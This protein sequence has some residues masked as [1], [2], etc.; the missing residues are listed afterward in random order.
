MIKD[1]KHLLEL[2]KRLQTLNSCGVDIS[3]TLI[4]D[5]S[6]KKIVNSICLVCDCDR[7]TVWIVDEIN[8]EL[9]SKVGKGLSTTIRLP[10]DVGIVGFVAITGRRLVIDDAYNDHRF[11]S[12]FDKKSGYKTKS[13]LTIPIKDIYGRVTGVIQAVNK[14]KNGVFNADDEGLAILLATHAG[15]MLKNSMLHDKSIIN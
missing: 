7:A 3:A 12:A 14:H 2:T 13:I 6:L 1:F 10:R 4:L 9:W 5:D 15:V 8:N 11:N